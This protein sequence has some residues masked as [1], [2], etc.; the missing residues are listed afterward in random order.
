MSSIDEN[1]G[2]DG[3]GAWGPSE[4]ASDGGTS[5]ER[6]TRDEEKDKTY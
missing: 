2:R 5:N 1:E 6:T 4:T 3:E